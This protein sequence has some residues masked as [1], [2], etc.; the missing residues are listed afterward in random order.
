MSSHHSQSPEDRLW[1]A[2]LIQAFADATTEK[3]INPGLRADY[4]REQAEANAEYQD[5]LAPAI[6]SFEAEVKMARKIRDNAIAWAHKAQ[7]TVVKRAAFI[8]LARRHYNLAVEVAKEGLAL[9]REGARATLKE[10]RD[11]Y[12]KL[13]HAVQHPP[14]GFVT[15]K[16]QEEARRWLLIFSPTLELACSASGRSVE[17]CIRVATLLEQNGWTLDFK[18]LLGAPGSYAA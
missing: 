17:A 7:A 4:L 10:R 16:E 8:E 2:V 12:K 1:S 3:V 13:K 14:M 15:V 9:S 11:Q 18:G 6:A 5:T